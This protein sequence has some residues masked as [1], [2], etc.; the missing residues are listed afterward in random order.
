MVYD[1]NRTP[2]RPD[3]ALTGFAGHDDD[4]AIS[5]GMPYEP[6]DSQYGKYWLNGLAGREYHAIISFGL[7]IEL[8]DCQYGKSRLNGLAGPDYDATI[9]FWAAL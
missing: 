4:A 8:G 3:R 2:Y 6:E 7:P 9:S 1:G 5:L